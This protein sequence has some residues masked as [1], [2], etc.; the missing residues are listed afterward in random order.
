MVI[1]P[2][3]TRS[4]WR[5]WKAVRKSVFNVD[6]SLVASLILTLFCFDLYFT[7]DEHLFSM[8]D[9]LRSDGVDSV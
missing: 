8:F 9:V 4:E 5:T 2:N 7:F 1:F 3:G 6:C